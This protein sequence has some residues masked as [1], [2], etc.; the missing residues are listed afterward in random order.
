M[1]TV[2]RVSLTKNLFQVV[3]DEWIREKKNILGLT[4]SW[5]SSLSYRNQFTD[6]QSKSMDWFLY[7]RG[8]RHERVAG[9]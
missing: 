8:L 4:L 2:H 5:Q 7:D 3:Q 9:Y 1:H 6:L